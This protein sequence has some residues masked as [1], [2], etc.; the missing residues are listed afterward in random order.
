MTLE[1]NRLTNAVAEMGR[2]IAGQEQTFERLL[3]QARTWLAEFSDQGGALRDAAL[4]I[5]AAVPTTEPLAAAFPLPHVPPRFT[6]IGADGAQIQPDRHGL[7]LYY[8]INVGS[9]V[10]RHGSGETPQ[11]RSVPQLCFREQEL[12]EGALLVSGN[13][14][15]VRRDLA[16]LTHLADLVEAEPAGPT[17][18]LVDGTLL[19][20]LME[21][22]PAQGRKEKFDAYL[23]QLDRIRRKGAAV[24]A[25]TS[26]PRY[27]EVGKLLHLAAMGG[28][29]R[30]AE[31]QPNPLERL[32][33]GDI[34]A[35]LASGERS[36]LFVSPKP[37]NAT[38]YTSE[39]H[40]IHLCYVNVAGAGEKPVVARVEMPAWVAETPPLLELVHGGVVAQSR[41]VGGFPYVLARADELAYV[42]GPERQRLEEMVGTA[43]L[44]AGLSPSASSKALYKSMTR[45]AG[46]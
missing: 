42:S 21:D 19:M 9:L 8:L 22:L 1:L 38:V 36:A 25:F 23:A 18:A 3:A 43:M 17:L 33:D 37:I 46:R 2:T 20:W 12:Y 16:E 4:K 14:L 35:F 44:A 26:R 45:R 40:T 28:D 5:G 39:G 34:F 6:V 10:Y 27:T 13:L 15:D 32:P 11:A 41:I 30:Q 29:P 31:G 24:A 7:A